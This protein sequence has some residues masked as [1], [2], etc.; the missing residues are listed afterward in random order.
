MNILR[1]SAGNF[2]STSKGQLSLKC[3]GITIILFIAFSTNAQTQVEVSTHHFWLW[4]FLGRLHPMIVHF[5]VGLLVFALVMEIIGRKNEKY[6]AAIKLLIYAGAL[7]AIIAV[8]FGL[9]LSNTEEY[10]SDLLSIHQWTGIATMLLSLI[11]AW[12]YRKS[13]RT[14]QKLLLSLTVAGVTI[15]VITGLRLPTVMIILPVLCQELRPAHQMKNNM[16][17][18]CRMALLM[19]TRYKSL[20]CRCV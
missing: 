3:F 1:F 12:S 6:N 4:S 18:L 2:T 9:L 7:S 10:G 17:W 5:P 8:A 16:H 15:A 13:Y 14:A 20:T 11:C 19:K